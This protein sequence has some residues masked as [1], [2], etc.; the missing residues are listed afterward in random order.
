[1]ASQHEDYELWWLNQTQACRKPS[2][3]THP[4]ALALKKQLDKADDADVEK[5]AEWYPRVSVDESF[6]AMQK[7]RPP[8]NTITSEVST[9]LKEYPHSYVVKF[10]FPGLCKFL[11]THCFFEFYSRRLAQIH[12]L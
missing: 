7:F 8:T 9:K 3:A 6:T 2:S 12:R 10:H 4:L 1:M 11:R 5:G